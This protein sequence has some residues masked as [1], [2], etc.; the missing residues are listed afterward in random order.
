MAPFSGSL[1]VKP[2]KA[3]VSE[4]ALSEFKQLLQLSKIGPATYENTFAADPAYGLSREWTQKAKDYW[5][6]EYDWYEHLQ[7]TFTF[8]I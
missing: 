2:F 5:L 4:E 8:I 3:S 6:N 1:E 7:P